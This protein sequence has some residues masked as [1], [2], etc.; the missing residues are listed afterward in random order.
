[1]RY[2]PSLSWYIALSQLPLGRLLAGS[3]G[4]SPHL[5]PE[6][7]INFTI[8]EFNM[9]S[10]YPPKWPKWAALP[11][12]LETVSC[13]QRRK[14]SI[15]FVILHISSA[16]KQGNPHNG[17][18]TAPSFIATRLR[19]K[20]AVQIRHVPCRLILGFCRVLLFCRTVL[21]PKHFHPL[22][23]MPNVKLNAL[24]VEQGKCLRALSKL[25][26]IGWWGTL[27]R[28]NPRYLHA[29]CVWVP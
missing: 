25:G 22:A 11:Q 17:V 10:I 18:W 16:F 2:W 3:E 19:Y 7:C 24:F 13:E 29:D 9:G 20:W 8:Q 5:R 23:Y 15:V 28:D 12:S 1:M 27:S 21:F 4:E 26:Y 14:L 6:H